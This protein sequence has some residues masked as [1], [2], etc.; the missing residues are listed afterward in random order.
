MDGGV[1]GRPAAAEFD[2]YYGRYIDRVVAPD[3]L[4]ALRNQ[5][6]EIASFISELD[7]TIAD[8]RYA[9]GKW[10][11]RQVLNHVCDTERIFGARALSVAR[12]ERQP[13]PGFDENAYADMSAADRRALA[14]L[15][16][17]LDQLRGATIEM[18]E[19]FEEDAWGRI[20]NANGSPVSVR[21]IAW[22]LAGHADHHLNV[23]RDRY[24]EV[25][26]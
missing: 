17:E 18:F 21:A 5:R 16:R 10:T 6:A 24:L 11:I 8:H 2:P 23:L 26:E 7:P 20:G 12:G 19:A 25:D 14:A 13:L 1:R 3:I 22:I 15:G 9:P 4:A